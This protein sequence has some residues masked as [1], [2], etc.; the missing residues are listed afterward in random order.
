MTTRN[1]VELRHLRYFIAL[2][3]ELHYRKAAEKLFIS[4]SA[5]SKQIKQ[6]ENLINVKLFDRNQRK[7]SLTEAGLY[8]RDHVTQFDAE[9]RTLIE[10]VQLI[11][12]GLEGELKIGYVG[13]AMQNVVPE[14][15]LKSQA[16]FPLIKYSLIEMSNKQQEDA[17]VDKTIDLGFLRLK[18]VH[19]ELELQPVLE[20]TFSL[21]LPQGHPID[22]IT[23]KNLAALKDENFILFDTDYSPLYFDKIVSICEDHG[24]KPKISHKSVHASTIFRLVEN[25][26]GISIV[27]SSL[28]LGF[29]LKIKFIPLLDVPQ[30]TML[31]VAWNKKNTNPSLLKVK[32]L[33]MPQKPFDATIQMH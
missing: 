2:A 25:K 12:T 22:T 17:L 21:V 32:G 18:R 29:D 9:L 24:F 11:S 20:D 31:S 3:E 8:L 33:L 7:V 6:L 28:A 27:P 26:V 23:K 30:R 15:L 14:L 10:R 5:L 4:Q 16:Q 13:S 19:A 1:L